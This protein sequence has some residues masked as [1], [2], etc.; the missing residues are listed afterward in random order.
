MLFFQT[1]KATVSGIIWLKFKLI[2]VSMVTLVTC[3][4][5]KDPIKNDGARV[6]TTFSPN[7]II[8]LWDF[9]VTLKDSK[10]RSLWSNRADFD[11]I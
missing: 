6:L 8:T 4:D 10:F 5:E 2:Q 9:F 1:F 7:N 11:I 3:K